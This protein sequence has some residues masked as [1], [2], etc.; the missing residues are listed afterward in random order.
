[1]SRDVHI[2]DWREAGSIKC[3]STTKTQH[4][5]MH[6]AQLSWHY[7]CLSPLNRRFLPPGL[8]CVS[9]LGSRGSCSAHN[10]LRKYV[11]ISW[12]HV[13][14]VTDWMGWFEARWI[15]HIGRQEDN[16]TIQCGC[17][18]LRAKVTFLCHSD[19]LLKG[20][21]KRPKETLAKGSSFYISDTCY[22]RNINAKGLS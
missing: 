15:V 4:L 8:S 9:C 11:G 5:L 21:L 13:K 7:K 12:Y 18:Q 10:S 17:F 16:P 6:F 14:S 20:L 22:F 1:M 3:A 2:D 19:D